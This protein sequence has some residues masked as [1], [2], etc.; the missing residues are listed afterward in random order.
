[1]TTKP[2]RPVERIRADIAAVN[3]R[4][5]NPNLRDAVRASNRQR[6]TLLRQELDAARAAQ[7]AT[8]CA[9]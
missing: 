3:D 2:P 6:L 8:P 4:L 5:A 7:E 9:S 1:M